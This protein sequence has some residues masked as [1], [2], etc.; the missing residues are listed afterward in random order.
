MMHPRRVSP[1]KEY[2]RREFERMNNSASLAEKFPQLKSLELKLVYFDA[3]GLT[4]TGEMRYRANV[5]H[6]KSVFSFACPNGECVGGDFDL[7]G[8]VA[9]AVGGQVHRRLLPHPPRPHRQ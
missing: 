4:K 5:R 2:R 6:A 3:D 7:S 1:R 8:V 9:Q